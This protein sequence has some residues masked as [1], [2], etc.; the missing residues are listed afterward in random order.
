[1]VERERAKLSR[2]CRVRRFA[3]LLIEISLQGELMEEGD[4]EKLS[5][6]ITVLQEDTDRLW[7]CP[8]RGCKGIYCILL[9]VGSS[10]LDLRACHVALS[11]PIAQPPSETG[12]KACK[13]LRKGISEAF[14]PPC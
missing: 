1:M 9:V 8:F 7:L 5:D 6:K 11:C 12:Q 3:L 14:G 2:Y 13:L 4:R 10:C